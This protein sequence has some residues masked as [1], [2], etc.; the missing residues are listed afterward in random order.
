MEPAPGLQDGPCRYRWGAA[1]GCS[2]GNGEGL[3]AAAGVYSQHP[4]TIFSSLDV[5]CRVRNVGKFCRREQG[6]GERVGL[7]RGLVS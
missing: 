7:L 6:F 5:A 3:G 2:L 1:V 4:S